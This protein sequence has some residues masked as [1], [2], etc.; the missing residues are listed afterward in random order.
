MPIRRIAAFPGTFDP[1]THGHLDVIQRGAQLFD[2]LIVGVSAESSKSPMLPL[3]ARVEICRQLTADIKN[4]RVASFTGMTISFAKEIGAGALLRGIRSFGDFEYEFQLA[5]A[6]RNLGDVETVFV[7]ASTENAFVRS[8]LIKEA[9][10][11]GADISSLVPPLVAEYLHRYAD[12]H[13]SGSV[14]LAG[15]EPLSPGKNEL[16]SG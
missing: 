5:L 6:N 2:E 12:N 14:G 16:C 10:R 1:L 11:L 7:I 3:T 13:S 8:T 15:G 9:F 4:V